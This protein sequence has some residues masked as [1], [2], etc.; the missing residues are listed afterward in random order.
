MLKSGYMSFFRGNAV[1]AHGVWWM[2]WTYLSQLGDL[3]KALEEF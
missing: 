1:R 2:F 3:S